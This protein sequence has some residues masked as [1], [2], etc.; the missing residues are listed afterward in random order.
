MLQ[1]EWKT[2]LNTTAFDEREVA[3]M[4]AV[5]QQLQGVDGADVLSD[6]EVVRDR[7]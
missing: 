4:H 2:M 1:D 7:G 3:A 6:R 5:K